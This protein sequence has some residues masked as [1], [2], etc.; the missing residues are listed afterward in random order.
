MSGQEHRSQRPAGLPVLILAWVLAAG[1][2]WGIRARGNIDAYM[3]LHRWLDNL[4]VPGWVRNIDSDLLLI[5]LGVL[6]WSLVQWLHARVAKGEKVHTNFLADFG[7]TPSGFARGLGL[8]IAFGLPM[9]VI[10]VV[11]A[12]T[13]G[14][15]S[16]VTWSELVPGLII[17]PINEEFF[18]R[19]ALVITLWRCG[20]ARFWTL[21]VVSGLLFGSAHIDW[22]LDGITGGWGTLL[23][24]GT[25]GV[26]F[27]WLARQW[28]EH[29]DGPRQAN[30]WVPMALHAMMNGAWLFFQGTDNAVGGVWPN[31]AR[32]AT[33]A[34]SAIVTIRVCQPARPAR[35]ARS[36]EDK[37]ST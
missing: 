21:A 26:W 36:P 3:N 33:I 34:I 23:V 27:A 10:G 13:T 30:L 32:G 6:I 22:T 18:Y 20:L 19:G 12:A 7:L 14:G 4:G 24:T 28:G 35:R 11:Y 25:G 15:W 37:P 1:G 31:V 16:T 17:A 5:L 2:F 29:F 9:L 8:G